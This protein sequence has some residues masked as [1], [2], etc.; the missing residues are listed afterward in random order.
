MDRTKRLPNFLVIGVQKGGTTTLHQIFLKHP[1]VYLPSCKEVHYFTLNSE[2]PTSWYASHFL[3]AKKEQ[4]VG[5]IE[6][7]TDVDDESYI[8]EFDAQNHIV[9]ALTPVCEFNEYFKTDFSDEEF[10]TIGGL[11]I[12]EFGRIPERGERTSIGHFQV[13]VVNAD[14]RQIK[15]IKVTSNPVDMIQK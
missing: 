15:L 10:S 9:K 6:D 2:T 7:E 1:K 3:E 8:K 11:V 4:I 5:D 12:Q 14:S 13:T